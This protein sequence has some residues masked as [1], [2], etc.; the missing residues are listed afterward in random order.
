MIESYKNPDQVTSP[1]KFEEDIILEKSL[2]PSKIDEFVLPQPVD[3][4]EFYNQKEDTS[5]TISPSSSDT[6]ISSIKRDPG[7]SDNLASLPEEE[8]VIVPIPQDGGGQE[9]PS[10][11]S[12]LPGS[13]QGL[14]QIRPTNF[15]NTYVIML[16]SNLIYLL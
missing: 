6:S 3:K 16:I 7:T 15:S 9:Q 4:S 2:R 14:P 12:V 10:G 5:G 8:P 13:G 11:G 1:D